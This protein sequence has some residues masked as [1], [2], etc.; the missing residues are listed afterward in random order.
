MKDE[1]RTRSGKKKTTRQ[2]WVERNETTR[3]E[4]KVERRRAEE[5]QT[6]LRLI[7]LSRLLDQVESLQLS[8]TLEEFD[9]LL[10]VEVGRKSSDEDLVDGIGDVGRD[11]SR[12]VRSSGLCSRLGNEILRT[13]NLEDGVAKDDVVEDHG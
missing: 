2:F 4:A 7:R 9:D 8:E 11:D 3:E 12:D 10:V 1:E 13:T 5:R 6:H